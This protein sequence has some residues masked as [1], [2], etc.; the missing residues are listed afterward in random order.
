[1]LLILADYAN[2]KGYAWPSRATIADKGE[3]SIDTVDRYLARLVELGLV[4]KQKRF[5]GNTKVYT[6][7]IYQL[8]LEPGEQRSPKRS[9]NGSRK[10]RPP[11]LVIQPG[12]DLVADVA[13]TC[14]QR[15]RPDAAGVAASLR[16]RVAALMRPLRG[17]LETF[18]E[19]GWPGR[20]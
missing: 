8:K 11:R 2:D 14:G 19:G 15:N 17:C 18:G 7:S 10:L 3:I 16:P 4:T 12:M 9:S 13:A 1:M 20:V 5:H 6:S